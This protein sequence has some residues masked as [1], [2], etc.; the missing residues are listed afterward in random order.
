[1]KSVLFA[2]SMMLLLTACTTAPRV[3]PVRCPVLPAMQ[4]QEP[5]PDF[6]ERMDNF[7]QGKLPGQT[8]SAQRSKPATGSTTLPAK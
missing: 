2:A 7:L 8:P 6:L 1:M 5:E 4:K 3:A